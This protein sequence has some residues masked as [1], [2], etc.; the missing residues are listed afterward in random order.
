MNGWQRL[1]LVGTVCLG[2]WFIGWWPLTMVGDGRNANLSYR[3]ELMV[4]FND[5]NCKEYTVRPLPTLR[6]P[7][8]TEPCYRIFQ[9]RQYDDT[10]PYTIEAYDRRDDEHWR[11]FYLSAVGWGAG[12]TLVISALVYLIGWIVG[13]IIRGFRPRAS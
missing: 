7:R 13:W 8:I 1:W 10:V 3:L 9:S 11:D 4:D 12:G 6:E 5:P 2:L